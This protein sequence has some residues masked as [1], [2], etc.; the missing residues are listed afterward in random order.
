MVDI[1]KDAIGSNKTHNHGHSLQEEDVL[2]QE[3]QQASQQIQQ[4]M[5]GCPVLGAFRGIDEAVLKNVPF[6]SKIEWKSP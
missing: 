5:S 4:A 1:L 3:A 2:L 6:F